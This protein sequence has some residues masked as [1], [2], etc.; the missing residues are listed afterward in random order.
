MILETKLIQL[1]DN[2]LA[3]D[4]S[5]GENYYTRLEALWILIQLTYTDDGS[6]ELV[7][8]SRQIL[9]QFDL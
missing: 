8:L 4:P 1:L 3:L 5:I 2:A 7:L 9:A 6:A